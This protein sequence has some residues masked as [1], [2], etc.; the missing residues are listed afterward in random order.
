VSRGEHDLPSDIA[1]ELAPYDELVVR[2]LK[3]SPA[4]RYNT[5]AEFRDAIQTCLVAVSPTISSD[6]LG[7]YLREVFA[8]EMNAHQELVERVAHMHL[9]DFR[10]QLT[11]ASVAT[12]S[13][14]LANMPLLAPTEKA[15][16]VP[17]KNQRPEQQR[18]AISGMMLSETPTGTVEIGDSDL[19]PSDATSTMARRRNWGVIVSAAI[20]LAFVVAV[21]VMATRKTTSTPAASSAPPDARV[22]VAQAPTPAPAV[23]T[24]IPPEIEIEPEPEPEPEPVVKKKV[25]PP[26]VVKKKVKE[27]ADTTPPPNPEPAIDADAVLAKFKAVSRE[28]KEFKQAYG[29]RL[30]GEWT[31]LA[32]KAQYAKGNP[33]K[34]TQLDK[35]L[36]R[37]RSLMKAQ[38]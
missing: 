36:D 13:F 15:T 2:A 38:K 33:E 37:F 19:V 4:D 30:D 1:P 24:P 32:T 22:A 25:A 21:I 35:K 23:I 9:D 11:T 20:A 6:Q 29:S 18:T 3:P 14:A 26:A 7:S 12:V 27:K 17:A 31:D 8:N 16:P 10:E 34:L 28:Y 5:A